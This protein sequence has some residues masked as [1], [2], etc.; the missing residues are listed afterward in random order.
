MGRL[1]LFFQDK[2]MKLRSLIDFNKIYVFVVLTAMISLFFSIT[3]LLPFSSLLV[4]WILILPLLILKNPTQHMVSIS[5]FFLLFYF[6]INILNYSPQVLT[7]FSFFRRDGNIFITM[8]P[9]FILAQ[10]KLDL[11]IDAI[12]KSFIYFSGIMNAIFIII[13]FSTGGTLFLFEHQIYHF[14]FI[15]HN[16]AGGFLAMLL[17][18][19]LAL[20]LKKKTPINLLIFVIHLYG[21]WLTNSRGSLIAIPLAI[22]ITF[23]DGKKIWHKLIVS[24][25]IIS[26]MALAYWVYKKHYTEGINKENAPAILSHRAHTLNDRLFN[27]WPRAIYLFKKSPVFGT[28]FGSFNDVPYEFSGIENFVMIMTPEGYEDNSAHAHHTF[29]HVLGETGLIGLLLLLFFLGEVRKYILSIENKWIRNAF[30]LTF[31]IAILS[32]LTEHRLFTPS[33][34][35]PFTILLGLSISHSRFHILS[36]TRITNGVGTHE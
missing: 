27:L 14:L 10:L 2:T 24:T 26:Q 12:F 22:I 28:G 18:F 11:D 15:A 19:S 8:A 30:F 6:M 1:N 35:L 21:L 13:Y 20:F 33:Q 32:S 36:I 3:N 16:A 5:L 4:V 34:M 31:W 25:L 9:L 23:L 17:G 7:R 29:F